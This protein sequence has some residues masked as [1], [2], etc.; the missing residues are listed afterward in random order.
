MEGFQSMATTTNEI[1]LAQVGNEIIE[2]QGE[3]LAKF[4]TNR[5]QLAKEEEQRI[6][7][8]KEKEIARA[9]LLARLGI[10]QEEAQLLLG[11]N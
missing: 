5:E 7:E 4:L 6:L 11:G 8:L 10:T 1:I 2:L 3:A 9:A